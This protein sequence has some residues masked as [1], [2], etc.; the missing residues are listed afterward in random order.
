LKA[1]LS[2]IV[3]TVILVGAVIYLQ[4]L[5]HRQ[6][7]VAT[8][9]AEPPPIETAIEAESQSMTVKS[10]PAQQSNLAPETLAQVNRGALFKTGSE[11][12]DL[13][14]LPE[15]IEVF[16]TLVADNPENQEGLLR[17]VECYS[18]PMV[19]AERRAEECWNRAWDLAE[20]ARG[21]T[22]LVSAFRSL[23]IDYMPAA[24]IAGLTEIVDRDGENVDARV[25]LARSLL[26]NGDSDG[27]E[28]YLRALLGGDQSLGR[29]REL[30]IQCKI[31]Q[32]ETEAAETLA[33]DLVAL[34]PEEPYPHV[35]LARVQ[36]IQG[37]V[38]DARELCNNALLLDRRYVPAIVSR[39]HA[40]TRCCWT[41][42][43]SPPSFPERTPI[44][45]R[46]MPG[47]RR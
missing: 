15:A 31:A 22:T 27:A 6:P 18:H 10:A 26:M 20:A 40:Y 25:L 28:R 41:D 23:F 5:P 7:E 45:R 14:H 24:A 43:T 29:V 46:G 39:A 33:K 16:E 2:T 42:D 9:P 47:R 36:M 34:Y 13:W 1:L 8:Q 38:E 44:L 37:N 19:G 11:L 30:L 35:L 12:L 3:L 21:D 4:S 17:L 32:N